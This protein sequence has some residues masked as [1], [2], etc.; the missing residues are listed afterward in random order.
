MEDTVKR[1]A[2]ENLDDWMRRLSNQEMPILAGTATRIASI[3]EKDRSNCAQMAC[4]ILED[5]SLTSRI[6]KV[7]NSA[8]IRLAGNRNSETVRRQIFCGIIKAHRLRG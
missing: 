8:I 3:A 6:L 7:A 5:A 1:E 4:A 2:L